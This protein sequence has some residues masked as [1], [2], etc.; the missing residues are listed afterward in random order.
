MAKI[1]V[2]DDES[3]IVKT[4]SA[5]LQDEGHDV[6]SS[7]TAK[8]ALTC[9]SN[10]EIDLVFLDV[11]LPDMDGVKVLEQIN[12]LYPDAA[13]IMISGHASI[14][15]A[16]KST[17]LGALDFL[18][19]PLSM[20]RVIT[21]LNNALERIM[22][23]KEN[24]RLRKQASFE[25]EMIG[26]SERI[27]EVRKTIET[28][29][30]TNARV[31]I[32]GEN[33]TGKEL[34]AKAIHKNSKRSSK[35]MV[36]VNCAAIP[37]ELI[38]SEL[39]GHEK[40]SFTGAANRRLGK[41]EISNGGTIFLDEI[42]DMSASAQ[43]KVL[44]VLQEQQF[45]RVGGNEPVT[46]DVRVIAATNIDVKKAIEEERFREDL[47]YR[48][49]VIPIHVPSLTE[50]K[51]DIP[52]LTNY[53]LSTF[54]E[55]HGLGEKSITDKAMKFL[56]KYNWPGNVRE[57]KNIIERLCIMVQAD[58]INKDDI[59]KYIE[60]DDYEDVMSSN[61][62]TLKQA[63]EEF[64]K[65]YIIRALKKNEKNITSTAKD[66][67]IERTNLHRKVKQYNINVDRI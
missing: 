47:Y 31:F 6:Y 60:S 3:N 51:E 39:F 7:E 67:G 11:W 61:T 37:D 59:A 53:F 34:V 63:R 33:G 2:V 40:G 52:L 23:R 54:S 36:K 32:T 20:Q 10:N 5:I 13:V 41:F 22:L 38:E 45:E 1:L 8:D 21:S 42:C 24:I 43:A 15:I 46:V 49:N 16:V 65:E 58:M 64:E 28:A 57:L 14:D 25:D 26:E 35:L 12:R 48:L 19:K 9:L 17:R 29:A 66:L 30:G 27:N 4:L 50:R 44:R 62:S 55:M 18:E 56:M